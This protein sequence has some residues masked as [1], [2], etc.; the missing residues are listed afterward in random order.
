M[1]I[2]V[3]KKTVAKL[4]SYRSY[5]CKELYKKLLSKGCEKEIAEQTIEEFCSAGILNDEEY[6][7]C[8]IHDGLVIGLKG[9][10]RLKQELLSK[11]VAASV[12]E[13][14]VARVDIDTAAQ[15]ESYVQLKFGDK[16]FSDWREIEKAKMH[17]MRRGYGISEINKCFKNLGISAKRGDFD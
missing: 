10:F 14:A 12:I 16:E 5:T 9:L 11:G 8:Y 6:A 3:A 7:F 17:L 4:I 2:N 1:D 13:R 15:L